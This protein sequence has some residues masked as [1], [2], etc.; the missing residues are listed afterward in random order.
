VTNKL[1]NIINNAELAAPEYLYVAFVEQPHT[2][3]D[4]EDCFEQEDL[5]NGRGLR[6]ILIV[7]YAEMLMKKYPELE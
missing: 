4:L 5:D 7:D 3:K 2:R 1:H 6:K